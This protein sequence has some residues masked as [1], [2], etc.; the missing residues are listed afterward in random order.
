MGPARKMSSNADMQL[1]SA[2]AIFTVRMADLKVETWPLRDLVNLKV[3]DKYLKSIWSPE[4]F[5]CV[6]V[7]FP[8]ANEFPPDS[9]ERIVNH[10]LTREAF[11]K[12]NSFVRRWP[13]CRA[14]RFKLTDDLKKQHGYEHHNGDVY[15]TELVAGCTYFSTSLPWHISTSAPLPPR[16]IV[17]SDG[18][19]SIPITKSVK[20]ARCSHRV[21]ENPHDVRCVFHESP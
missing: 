5:G 1:E 21:M 2:M 14:R 6:S 20:H 13:G 15:F 19:T 11:V 12:F 10:P 8:S 3:R 7:A 4:A 18:S 16:R 17:Q 9:W